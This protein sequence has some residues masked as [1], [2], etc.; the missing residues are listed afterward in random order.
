[1]TKLL[2]MMIVNKT[3]TSLRI[4]FY[5]VRQSQNG[6]DRFFARAHCDDTNIS[7]FIHYAQKFGVNSQNDDFWDI[8]DK[9]EAHKFYIRKSFKTFPLRGRLRG[10][11]YDKKGS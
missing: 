10:D 1:M 9:R 2:K 8:L 11:R 6:R 7:S 3:Y 4:P 5:G